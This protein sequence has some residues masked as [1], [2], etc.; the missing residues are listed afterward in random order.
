MQ[1]VVL[2]IMIMGGQAIFMVEF[3]FFS[4]FY[5]TIM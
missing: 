1:N 5:K 2:G 3:F 4:I